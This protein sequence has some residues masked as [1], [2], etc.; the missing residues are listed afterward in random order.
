MHKGAATYE[1]GIVKTMWW[2]DMLLLYKQRSRWLGVVVQ[3]LLFWFMIGSGMTSVFRLPGVGG[4]SSYLEFFYPGILVMILL[5]TTIFASMSIIEDRQ[6]GF[7]QGVL[8][9][10]GSRVSLV[11][12]KVAGVT[13]VA[14]VQAAL[15]VALSP[16]AGLP[17]AQIH[18]IALAGTIVIGCA[19]LTAMSFVIAW[20]LNSSQGYHAIMGVVLI[21]LWVISGAMFPVPV[22]G[23]LHIV[24]YFNPMSYI[25]NGARL[26]MSP[27]GVPMP[28]I[29]P[30]LTLVILT[31]FAVA[32]T[33]LA[34]R[35]CRR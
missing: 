32:M 5:F 23:W 15:F 21:P 13:S 28:G 9:A 3:P 22:S 34:A 18:W 19:G 1:L 31:L 33:A 14:A 25:V 2:R 7:L 17:Y 4:N 29:S 8:V 16:V 27:A 10:P 6:S 24:M 20:T 35:V 30:L 26:A 11:L 12:G